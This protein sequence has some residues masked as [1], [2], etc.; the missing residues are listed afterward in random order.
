MHEKKSRA[1]KKPESTMSID[2][3]N[4]LSEGQ[5]K[6]ALRLSAFGV[7]LI[8]PVLISYYNPGL[9]FKASSTNLLSLSLTLSLF[10]P[11]HLYVFLLKYMFV[12]AV[13]PSRVDWE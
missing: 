9:F 3:E 4:M 1:D 6:V 2:L 13:Q 5:C 12:C 8:P 7:S 10:I 11:P